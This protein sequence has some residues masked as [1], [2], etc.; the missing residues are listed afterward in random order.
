MADDSDPR[1][2]MAVP[3][4]TI[5]EA[6]TELLTKKGF[7]A[8]LAI[9]GQFA[10]PAG[11]LGLEEVPPPELVVRV[12]DVAHAEGARQAIDTERQ[13]IADL[14]ATAAKRQA[15]TGTV[16]AACEDC[17]KSSEWPA[18][19]MGTTQVCPHCTGY[20]DV[21]DPDEE[22]DESEYAGGEETGGEG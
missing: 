11:G 15:R 1:V 3:E 10:A 13:A 4:R 8:E 6:V 12:L 9:V 19:D 2:I 21:P 5:G 20:M 22:W 16:T 14:R 18:V 17:G 7:P